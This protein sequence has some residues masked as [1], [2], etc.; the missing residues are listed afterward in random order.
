MYG[1]RMGS[2]TPYFVEEYV[3]RTLDSSGTATT[4]FCPTW[5]TSIKPN[6]QEKNSL[7]LKT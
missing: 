1:A 7:T 5:T 2:E 3:E 6:V 4:R